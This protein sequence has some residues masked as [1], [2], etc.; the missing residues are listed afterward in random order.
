MWVLCPLLQSKGPVVVQ[1]NTPWGE[2]EPS[3]N[4][5]LYIYLLIVNRFLYY[6]YLHITVQHFNS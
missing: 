3:Y 2:G 5:D 4:D 1:T 6:C